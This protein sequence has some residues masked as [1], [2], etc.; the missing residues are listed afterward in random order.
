MSGLP[1]IPYRIGD[2]A[3]LRAAML[4]HVADPDLLPGRPNPFAGWRPGTDRDFHTLFVE[5]WAYLGD[6]LTFYQERIAN[7]AYLPT[8]TERDALVR[9]A[10]LVDYVA[11]PGAAAET[12]LAFALDK[13]ARLTIPAGTRVSGRGKPPPVFETSADLAASGA[14][15]AVPF[16]PVALVNQFARLSSFHTVFSMNVQTSYDYL[17]VVIP[18]FYEL[19]GGF[20]GF[21][22][23]GFG[24]ID[25]IEEI[26]AQSWAYQIA[27]PVT[28]YGTA[29]A[30]VST[31]HVT[32]AGTSLRLHPGDVVLAVEHD[33]QRDAQT[34]KENARWF[35]LTAVT[36]DRPR[37]TTTVSWDEA[38]TERNEAGQQVDLAYADS[39]DDPVALYALR[40]K[41]GCFGNAAPDYGTLAAELPGPKAGRRLGQRQGR[42]TSRSRQ[43]K[44][45][46]RCST[47]STPA[48]AP[49]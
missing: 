43:D 16:S 5:L 35:R 17:T 9:L 2:F 27:I 19:F 49:R 28:N 8:A 13:D 30:T 26:Y 15:S 3:T 6:V 37:G 32:L 22:E 11:A 14:L 46:V 44:D 20:G 36:V 25:G 29:A 48:C 45:R 21:G 39:A 34:S 1:P 31:R 42:G 10:Q 7:E 47:A 41:A 4:S 40:V 38:Q 24:G 18:A 33:G 23:F 12:L